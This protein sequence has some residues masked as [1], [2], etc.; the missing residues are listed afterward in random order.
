MHIQI[1]RAEENDIPVICNIINQLTPGLPHDYRDAVE[2]FTTHIKH[3]PD[4]Y[5]WV[6]EVDGQVVGTAMMHLQHKLSYNCGTA[7]HLEDV[8]VEYTWR[9]RGIGE[10]LVEKAIQTAKLHNAY[11]LMLTCFPKTTV[12]YEKF[13]FKQHDIGMKL[14]LKE[15]YPNATP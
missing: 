5:L 14:V 11:K 15:E 12:Y 6:A 9:G 2:K 10:A 1:R 3:N 7:C 8:V 13:G 4:Y